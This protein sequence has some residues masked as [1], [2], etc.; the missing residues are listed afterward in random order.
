MASP[1]ILIVD[2]EE[3]FAKNT[4]KLL[5]HRGYNAFY[6]TN[7]DTAILALEKTDFDVVILDLR[8]PGMDGLSIFKEIVK[9]KFTTKVLILAIHGYVDDALEAIKL[10]AYDYLLK[11]CGIEELTE[12]IEDACKAPPLYP[13]SV[14]AWP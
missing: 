11:P 3:V 7:A 8:L 13:V 9:L 10:G 6:V 12:K 1:R 14:P 4:T 2:D 5:S